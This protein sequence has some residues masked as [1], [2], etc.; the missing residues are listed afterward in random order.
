MRALFLV[1]TDMDFTSQQ[2]VREGLDKLVEI[3]RGE[4]S[5]FRKLSSAILKQLFE[6]YHISKDQRNLRCK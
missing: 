2:L 4:F 1:G 6:L 5:N 3:F